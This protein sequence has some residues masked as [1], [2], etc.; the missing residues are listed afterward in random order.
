M[1]E[2]DLL[3]V[4]VKLLLLLAFGVLHFVADLLLLARLLLL[5]LAGVLEVGVAL[6]E[7]LVRVLVERVVLE[8]LACTGELKDGVAGH[9]K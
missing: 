8:V 6:E 7:V 5:R 4:L 2:L 3:L 9:R 1:F